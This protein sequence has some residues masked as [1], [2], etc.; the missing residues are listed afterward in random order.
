MIDHPDFFNVRKVAIILPAGPLSFLFLLILINFSWHQ[1]R[2]W[3]ASGA[4]CSPNQ[5]N[6]DQDNVIRFYRDCQTPTLEGS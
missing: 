1:F 2:A 4:Q 5:D 6:L 3:H